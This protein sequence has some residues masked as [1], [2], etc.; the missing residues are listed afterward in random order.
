MDRD[1]RSSTGQT[2]LAVTGDGTFAVLA[3]RIARHR[4]ARGPAQE[5]C[6]R[7]LARD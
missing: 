7:D 1:Q 4:A 2:A 3:G 6:S 5:G